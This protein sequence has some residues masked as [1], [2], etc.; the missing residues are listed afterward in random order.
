MQPLRAKG[1]ETALLAYTLAMIL[2]SGSKPPISKRL[3]EILCP[4]KSFKSFATNLLCYLLI[5]THA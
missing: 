3:S 5:S 1:W 4:G 2:D